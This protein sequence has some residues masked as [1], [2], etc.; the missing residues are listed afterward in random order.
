[1]QIIR[2]IGV[3]EDD[4]RT[5]Y[6]MTKADGSKSLKDCV[7]EIIKPVGVI[8][9]DDVNTKGEEI[10][11]ISIID[12]NFNVYAGQ[13]NTFKNRFYEIDE[14]FDIGE[15]EIKIT[16]GVTKAGREYVSCTLA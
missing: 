9:Y 13:S 3:K 1:M 4:K 5:I 6:K 8:E 15:Y 11:M 10:H 7:G 2:M 12:E 16:S 14:M